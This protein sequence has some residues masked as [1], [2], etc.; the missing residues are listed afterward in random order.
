M[1]GIIF[2]IM[3]VIH[4]QLVTSRD[5]S[6]SEKHST[7]ALPEDDVAINVPRA[8]HIVP[9]RAILISSVRVVTGFTIQKLLRNN[10]E[11]IRI[12]N[13]DTEIPKGMKWASNITPS[14]SKIPYIIESRLTKIGRHQHLLEM[15]RQ[16]KHNGGPHQYCHYTNHPSSALIQHNP[17]DKS[18]TYRT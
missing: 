9:I 14:V 15:D 17:I 18:P 2:L 5:P 12:V 13:A 3:P 11:M 16:S 7:S 8:S 6:A 10:L 4:L 1:S